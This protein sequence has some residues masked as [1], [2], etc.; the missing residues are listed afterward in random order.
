MPILPEHQ[1]GGTRAKGTSKKTA[2]TRCLAR[3]HDHKI[4]RALGQDESRLTMLA[5]ALGAAEVI[6]PLGVAP[7]G[8][9]T[10][11]A[12]ESQASLIRRSARPKAESRDGC[13]ARTG[14]DERPAPRDGGNLPHS[15]PFTESIRVQGH[16]NG[17]ARAFPLLATV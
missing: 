4:Q 11:T 12:S 8:F 13:V 14:L 17:P 2:I 7:F 1:R 5:Y 9:G 3:P 6:V 15:R 16:V 10:D